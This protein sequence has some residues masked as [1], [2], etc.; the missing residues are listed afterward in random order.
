[1]TLIRIILTETWGLFVDDGALAA[2]L[3]LWGVAGGLVLPGLSPAWAAPLLFLGFLAI[4]LVN[5][6]LAARRRGL[7]KPSK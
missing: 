5:V 2:A 4:L 6:L 1:M 7:V 3:V